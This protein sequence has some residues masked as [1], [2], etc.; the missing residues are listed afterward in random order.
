[1]E[2]SIADV[3]WSGSTRGCRRSRKPEARVRETGRSSREKEI[4]GIMTYKA[5][6]FD[7][8]GTL[9]DTLTDLA[10]ATNCAL[11]T[12]GF[13]EHARESYKTFVGDGVDVLMQRVLPKDRRDSATIA[14]CAAL[15]QKE[16]SQ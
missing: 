3:F 15:M 14:E 7:L 2:P 8:D 13:P 5:I 9:L 1:M 4:T 16:Y 11:R 6:I 10:D 12:L